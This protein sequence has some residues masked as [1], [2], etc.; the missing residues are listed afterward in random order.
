MSVGIEESIHLQLRIGLDSQRSE[1]D[2]FC[3]VDLDIVGIEIEAF[4]GYL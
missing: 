3:Q 2:A 1:F 4:C